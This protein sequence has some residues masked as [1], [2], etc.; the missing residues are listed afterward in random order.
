MKLTL[1][2]KPNEGEAYRV[3]TNLFVVVAWERKFKTKASAL[4]T[5]LGL[6]DLAFLAYEAAKQSGVTVPAVFD[7][8]LKRIEA[9]TVVEE[10]DTNPTAGEPS[11]E[12]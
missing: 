9:I 5:A 6:E 3:T 12:V 11:A 7:D 1:E 2:V 8:Y 10:H 4:A